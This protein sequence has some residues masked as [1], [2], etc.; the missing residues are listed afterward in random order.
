MRRLNLVKCH[1]KG[2]NKETFGD[3]EGEKQMMLARIL[4]LDNLDAEGRLNEEL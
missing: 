4:E 2:W 1:I 3:V